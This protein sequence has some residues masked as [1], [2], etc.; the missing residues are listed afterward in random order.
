VK[1][2]RGSIRRKVA[3]AALALT[4]CGPLMAA[5][6][7]PQPAAVP[8]PVEKQAPQEQP[9]E[10]LDEVLVEGQRKRDRPRSWDDYQQPFNFLSHLVGQFVVD[11]Q[12]DLHAQGNSEDLRKV[13]GRINCVG[14][15]SAPGVQCELNVRWPETRGPDGVEIPGGVSTLDPAV[16][17]FGFEPS[18]PGVSYVTVDNRGVMDTAVGRMTSPNTMLARAKCVAVPGDCERIARMTV[19]PDLNTIRMN[20][21]LAI[22]QRKSVSFAFVMNRVAGS[23]SVVYGRKQQ[24]EKKK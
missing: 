2:R 14:F 15:G 22:D 19:E 6:A 23:A 12:V 8:H 24:K 17:L 10:Q 18:A 5:G 20:I 1:T 13:A 11:G 9:S 3:L 4:A 16:L 21:D 7:I